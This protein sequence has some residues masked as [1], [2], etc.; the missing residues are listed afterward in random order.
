MSKTQSTGGSGAMG[1][2]L[3][4]IECWHDRDLL[5]DVI[6]CYE[7]GRAIPQQISDFFA[8][9]VSGAVDAR[10]HRLSADAENLRDFVLTAAIEHGQDEWLFELQRQTRNFLL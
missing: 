3:T 1:Q 6:G 10:F 7:T 5:L 8:Q 4:S 9:N 2:K